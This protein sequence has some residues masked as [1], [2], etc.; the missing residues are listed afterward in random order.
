MPCCPAGVSGSTPKIPDSVPSLA[1]TRNALN[2]T[3][4]VS[5][6]QLYLLHTVVS[7][8][9]G[10]SQV[11]CCV[12]RGGAQRG[13]VPSGESQEASENPGGLDCGF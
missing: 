4:Q 12:C 3:V 7:V 11:H 9:P 8:T 10:E 1:Q 13:G 5:L 2:V 6:P